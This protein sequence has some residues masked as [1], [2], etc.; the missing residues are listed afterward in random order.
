[1][2]VIKEHNYLTSKSWKERG[3]PFPIHSMRV[4][5]K[6]FKHTD[7]MYLP[8]DTQWRKNIRYFNGVTMMFIRLFA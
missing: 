8:I 2:Q 6:Y 5:H 7:S 1:M 3:T 4:A